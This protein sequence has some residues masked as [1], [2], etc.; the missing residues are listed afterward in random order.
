MVCVGAFESFFA[1]D[2]AAAANAPFLIDSYLFFCSINTIN[3]IN[4][5]EVHLFELMLIPAGLSA[6]AI[7]A[8]V[9]F[10]FIFYLTSIFVSFQ[11]LIQKIATQ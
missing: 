10:S 2:D 7:A 9:L 6:V 5:P 8:I 3:H 1:E 11:E 4:A